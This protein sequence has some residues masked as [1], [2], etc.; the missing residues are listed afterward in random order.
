MSERCIGFHT[1]GIRVKFD[2]LFIALMAMGV[3]GGYYAEV[4]ALILALA[5][6]EGAHLLAASSLGANVEEVILLPFGARISINLVEAS[7]ETE[8]LT[9]LAGPMANFATA[10]F[11]FMMF[12]QGTNHP[13]MRELIHRQLQLGFFNLMPALPLDGGRIFELWLRERTNYIFASRIAAKA[14][15]IF[16]GALLCLSAV[17]LA[18]GKFP[19]SFLL[20]AV[21]LFYYANLEERQVPLVFMN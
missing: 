14:G 6:H 12:Q 18:F 3:L 20:P 17:S 10:I 19:L 4:L 9:V 8:L 13:G 15:K 1:R 7:P 16:A 21:F 11:L 2:L 5:V